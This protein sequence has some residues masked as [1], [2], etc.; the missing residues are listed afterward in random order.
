[1]AVIWASPTPT[2]SLGGLGP[3]PKAEAR[4][5]DAEQGPWIP[6]P[7]L[8]LLRGPGEE[9]STCTGQS[10]SL[11]ESLAP[12]PLATKQKPGRQAWGWRPGD[13]GASATGDSTRQALALIPEIY[14]DSGMVPLKGSA[15]QAGPTQ[16][17]SSRVRKQ[18]SPAPRKG[19]C[20]NQHV[21]FS[22]AT[23]CS[24]SGGVSVDTV[25]GV[26][27]SFAYADM[28]NYSTHN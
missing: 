1:M 26:T 13:R 5:A 12:N 24:V 11:R 9:V 23:E 20:V 4:K 18:D 16:L 17:S 10:C 7:F 2:Q 27:V 15:G 25:R 8:R 3:Q 19:V 28:S 21:T 22:P 14:L 6:S